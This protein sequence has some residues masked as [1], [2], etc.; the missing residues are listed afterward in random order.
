VSKT[1]SRLKLKVEESWESKGETFK[2]AGPR[3]ENPGGGRKGT[4]YVEGGRKK[5]GWLRLETWT[6]AST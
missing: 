6:A 2:K 5:E 3:H 4:P 1:F